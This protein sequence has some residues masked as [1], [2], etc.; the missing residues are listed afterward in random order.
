MCLQAFGKFHPVM[1][2]IYYAY[3]KCHEI[4]DKYQEAYE[5]FTNNYF[6]SKEVYGR[7][8][9]RTMKARDVLK[10]LPLDLYKDVPIDLKAVLDD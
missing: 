6:L 8:H 9:K 2:D 5:Y 1:C 10:K 7:E 3:G 4:N